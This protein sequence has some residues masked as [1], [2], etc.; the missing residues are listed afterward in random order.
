MSGQRHGKSKHEFLNA[1]VGTNE[2]I[3]MLYT[4]A[5]TKP[6]GKNVRSRLQVPILVNIR[7]KVNPDGYRLTAWGG[8]ADL[9]AKALGKG[10][11]MVY[12]CDGNSYWANVFNKAGVQVMNPDGTPVQTQ[13][14]AFVVR[15]FL[16]G[17]DSEDT[18]ITEINAGMRPAGWN[19][20]PGTPDNLAWK[21]ILEQRKQTF[22]QGGEVF[23]YA[24]VIGPKTPGCTILLGDQSK[25]PT[26]TGTAA[27]IPGAVAPGTPVPGVGAAVVNEV[28]NV[29]NA[30]TQLPA[31]Q[32]VAV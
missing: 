17:D 26:N 2:K 30:G 12:F 3:K 27:A 16:W 5:H 18:K 21:A 10:K 29:L 9:F 7:N 20:N 31:A 13:R 22:Y 4:P 25:L 23:G 6:D 14:T 15:D 24:K 1:R 28:H 32:N 11:A 8:L 19:G